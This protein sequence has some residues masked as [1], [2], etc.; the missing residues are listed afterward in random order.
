VPDYISPY[1]DGA[2]DDPFAIAENIRARLAQV[3]PGWEL[4]PAS[5]EDYFIEAVAIEHAETRRAASAEGQ[6]FEK[7]ARW[8]GQFVFGFLPSDPAEASGAT[9]WT[10]IDTNGPY[11]VPAGTQ[12]TL[13]ADDGSRVGFVTTEGFTIPNGQTTVSGVRIS[14]LETGDFTNGLTQGLRLEDEWDFIATVITDGPTSGGS[15]GETDAEYLNRFIRRQRRLGEQLIT[16]DDFSAFARDYFSDGGRAITI[17]LYDSTTNTPDVA[18]TFT[19]FP[20]D[21]SGLAR[22]AS[23]K[24]S[25]LAAIQEKLLTGVTAGVLDPQYTS[26]TVSFTATSYPAY[27]PSQVQAAAVAAIQ[28]FLDPARWGLAPYGDD[29]LWLNEQIVRY[30]DLVGVLETVEGLRWVTSLTLNGGVS[31]VALGSPVGL[32]TVGPVNGNVIATTS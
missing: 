26:I 13:L 30:N 24:T 20:I 18:G 3:I 16:A 9:T 10:A 11:E 1:S 21:G 15:D 7:I 31:N 22:S 4:W 32:P 14:A 8:L 27:Q 19:V 5:P 6:T 29:V 12:L 28:S 23:Q 2:E 17:P 25:L